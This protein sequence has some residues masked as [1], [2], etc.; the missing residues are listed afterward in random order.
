MIFR[1]SG[2][3]SRSTTM[4]IRSAAQRPRSLA[5]ESSFASFPSSILTQICALY[6]TFL[7]VD[8]FAMRCNLLQCVAMRQEIFKKKIKLFLLGFPALLC[9][10]MQCMSKQNQT[11]RLS[12]DQKKRLKDLSRATR[13]PMAQ[14]MSIGIDAILDYADRHGGKLVLPLNFNERF[15][16]RETKN[17]NPN[18]AAVRRDVKAA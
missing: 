6:F 4:R 18:S 5:R 2:P 3:L 11:V 15:E 8:F 10:T 12:E 7:D 17:I 13:L 9:I 16:V 14:L 1:P